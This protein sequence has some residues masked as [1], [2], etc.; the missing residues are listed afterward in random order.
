MASEVCVISVQETTT[1]MSPTLTVTTVPLIVGSMIGATRY[2]SPQMMR[3]S[4]SHVTAL[5]RTQV[6]Y[7]KR[8]LVVALT[9]L[10]FSALSITTQ[11]SG[12]GAEL[13]RVTHALASVTRS[14]SMSSTIVIMPEPESGITP[15]VISNWNL[16]RQIDE[17]SI[18]AH[19]WI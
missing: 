15:I 12:M 10:V 8:G 6:E 2:H 4:M 1:I 11:S 18:A 19:S 9:P 5:V 16:K 3:A 13:E 7:A 17:S 14:R